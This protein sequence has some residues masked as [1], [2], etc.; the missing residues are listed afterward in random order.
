MASSRLDRPS[1]ASRGTWAF[2]PILISN[3]LHSALILGDMCDHFRE[4]M[5][6][7]AKLNQATLTQNIDQ[8]VMM[9]TALAQ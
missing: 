7:G 9:V 3:Y 8:S 6:E 1:L 2:R 5:V 4:F